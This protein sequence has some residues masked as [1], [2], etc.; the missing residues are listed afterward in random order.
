L[1][2]AQFSFGESEKRLDKAQDTLIGILGGERP[3]AALDSPQGTL[4]LSAEITAKKG[5]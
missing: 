2:N 1:R 4:A 3:E 5:A